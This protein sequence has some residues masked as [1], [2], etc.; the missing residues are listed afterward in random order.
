MAEELDEFNTQIV[1]SASAD[2]TDVDP[3]AI[4]DHARSFKK[5][6]QDAHSGA[7]SPSSRRKGIGR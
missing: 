6:A 2:G 4:E 7:K 3:R 1:E 5:D